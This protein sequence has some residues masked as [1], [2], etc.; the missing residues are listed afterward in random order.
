MAERTL[1]GFAAAPGLAAGPAVLPAAVATGD[2][3][4]PLSTGARRSHS[5]RAVW[6]LETAAVA[7]EEMAAD[8]RQDGGADEAE[9]IETGALMARDPAL[10]AA[11]TR[12]ILEEGLT[13]PG[14]LY[15]A[16]E[17]IA[18]EL[19]ELPDPM[20]AERADD[21][22][23]VG[24]R[25]A[26]IAA[27]KRGGRSS[28]VLVASALG[29]GDVAGL[30][31]GVRAVALAGGGVTA[32]AAIVAR[33]LGLPMVVG[34]GP[35]ALDLKEGETVVVDG[36]LGRL[37]RHPDHRR[38]A[39]ARADHRRRKHARER[40]VARR[41]RP[42]TTRDGRRIGVLASATSLAEIREALQQG[43]EGVGLLRTELLF[44]DAEAWPDAERHFRFLAPL[45]SS[46]R[47]RGATVRL[48]DFGADKTPPFLAGSKGRGVELL[49][50]SP[51]ALQAQLQ[52]I[53]RA[54]HGVELRILI[55]MVTDVGQVVAVR[56]ALS[57]ELGGGLMPALGA[58]IEAPEAAGRAAEL[59][60]QLDFLSLGT[61]DLSQFVLGL[62]RQT[63]GPPAVDHPSVLR[64]IDATMRAGRAAQIPVE[65]CGEAA[66]DL[67]VLPLLV[68]LGTDELSVGAARVGEVREAVRRLNFTACRELA[69]RAL[70]GQAG[71]AGGQRI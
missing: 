43:A 53:L 10:A 51:G 5:K 42:A 49:L 35:D 9:I 59:A 19:A 45:L 3:E 24:R 11:V 16:A 13:A 61:N 6:A 39:Q 41:S 30:G 17:S 54:A 65:V 29:P 60:S 28:G 48:L 62:D 23:S 46:L 37:V 70:L 18:G 14:A 27:G 32:H 22:R 31:S 21:V 20:L 15:E 40:A 47:G 34:L 26:A 44:L 38:L 2:P 36:S 64:L 58:M 50:L 57:A 52:A 25:A 1:V 33:S 12:L 4:K 68:G 71:H 69:G 55:P 66:S 7:L 67:N 63:S 8:L 56:Q